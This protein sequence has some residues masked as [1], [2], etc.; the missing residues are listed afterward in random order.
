MLLW[1]AMKEHTLTVS[2][3]GT[4]LADQ[5]VGE[6]VAGYP[7]FSRV[8]QF[9]DMGFCCQGKLTLREACTRKG[10][11]LETV[12]QAL[13]A[14]KNQAEPTAVNPTTLSAS[15]LADYI[16]DKHHGFLRKEL[17]RIH[18]MAE[19]VADVHGGHTPSLIEL[20]EVFTRMGM[21]LAA[22]A[23]KEEHILFPRI[24]ELETAQAKAS[25]LAAPIRQMM[26]EHDST[27]AAIER[28][29][30]LTNGYRPPPEACNTY[31]AL[32]AGLA[33]LEADTVAHIHLEN[34]VLFPRVLAMAG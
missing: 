30:E 15:E 26:A 16:V 23:K 7:N 11:P 8:F 28:I 17:P 31:R 12:L 1:Q 29:R 32:F 3:P 24:K 10:V 25:V 18:A 21:E 6:I 14:E 34:E 2:A 9:Y 27:G 20:Y 4:P 33:D 13:E 19:R 5:T 22:H